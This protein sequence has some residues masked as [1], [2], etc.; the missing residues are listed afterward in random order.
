LKKLLFISLLFA[1]GCSLVAL[2]IAVVETTA[3]VAKIPVSVIG[4]VADAVNGDD[5][6]EDENE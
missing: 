1:G 4:S 6:K 2:P 3:S 5:N